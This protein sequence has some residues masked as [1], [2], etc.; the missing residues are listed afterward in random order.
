MPKSPALPEST[1]GATADRPRTRSAGGGAAGTA[2]EPAE[3][4]GTYEEALAELDQL[5][6]RMESGQLPLDQLLDSYR[7]GALLLNFCR[8]RLDAVETQVQI[9]E[10]GQLKTWT[11]GA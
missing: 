8:A 1:P 10:D 6:A 3:F 5:V 11:G 9:L 2:A 7:R 4:T